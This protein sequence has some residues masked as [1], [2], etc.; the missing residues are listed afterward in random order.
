M[1]RMVREGLLIFALGATLV[2][3]GVL[4]YRAV[5]MGR[6]VHAAEEPIRPWMTVPYIAHSKHIS[7]SALWSAL[8][9]PSH[10]HDHRPL[11]RIARDQKRPVNDVISALQHALEHEKAQP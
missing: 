11:A 1:S 3:T 6:R 10:L 7:Q 4:S 9:I 2:A 8:G 5:N